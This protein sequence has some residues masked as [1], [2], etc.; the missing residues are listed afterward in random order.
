MAVEQDLGS[1][2]LVVLGQND[3]VAGGVAH[4]R[5]KA[6]RSQIPA[7]PLGA[8]TGF[9]GIGRIGRDRLEPHGLEQTI[10]RIVEIGVDM[11][12]D[13]FKV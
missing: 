1:R 8:G 3:R 5:G 13:F 4:L 9:P 2:R 6:D 7:M 11:G 10:E 12:K